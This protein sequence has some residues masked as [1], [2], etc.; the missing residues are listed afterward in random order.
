ME[1]CQAGNQVPKMTKKF[2]VDKD[3]SVYATY[4]IYVIYV[5]MCYLTYNNIYIYNIDYDII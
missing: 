5:H 1:S 4:V 3:G 2:L